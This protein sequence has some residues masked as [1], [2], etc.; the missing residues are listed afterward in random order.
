MAPWQEWKVVDE[1]GQVLARTHNSAE[2][3]EKLAANLA[4]RNGKVTVESNTVNW[5]P[6]TFGGPEDDMVHTPGV[7]EKPIVNLLQIGDRV[8]WAFNQPGK[9]FELATKLAK[10]Y[11]LS[12][13]LGEFEELKE[14]LGLRAEVT[15]CSPSEL[16]LAMRID[17]KHIASVID[18]ASAEGPAIQ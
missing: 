4:V 7:K 6:R 8:S 1:S 18:A 9:P 12:F 15:F 13:T 10:Q 14:K 5:I 16:E 17:E 3:A 2:V 11:G